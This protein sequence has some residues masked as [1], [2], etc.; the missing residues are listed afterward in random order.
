VTAR[1]S[2]FITGAAA[3]IGA[4]TARLFA[5]RGWRVGASDVDAAGLA[6]LQAELG[7]G[8]VSTHVA[9]VRD[10]ASIERALG[11]F[12]SGADGRLDAVFANAGVL[13]MGPN[14][15]ITR[16]QKDLLVDVN[17]RGVLHT[18]DAAFPW[19]RQTPGSHAV[20]MCSTSAEY[21]APE[22]AVYSATKFFVRGLTEALEIEYRRYGIQVSA[23]YVAYVKTGMVFD[24][25][26]KPASIERLGVKVSPSQVA[27]TAWRAVHGR[28]SHWRVGLD[29]RAFNLLARLLG[30]RMASVSAWL[31]RS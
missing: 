1:Q 5:A 30:S 17:V 15:T 28:R 8:Q 25:K 9:D 23:I 24:A 3:G 16:V 14:E 26:V 19:L 27:E 4:E 11:E 31:M 12:V 18:L 20:A 7:T 2:V 29:A 10:Y 13:F 22:H 21:G 6:A